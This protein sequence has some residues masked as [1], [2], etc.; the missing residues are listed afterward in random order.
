MIIWI[1]FSWS[2]NCLANLLLSFFKCFLSII[3]SICHHCSWGS[4]LLIYNII[5]PISQNLILTLVSIRFSNLQGRMILMNRLILPLSTIPIAFT[6]DIFNYVFFIIILWSLCL[7]STIQLSLTLTFCHSLI[8][9]LI[10]SGI[11]L[12]KLFFKSLKLVNTTSRFA[13]TPCVLLKV[14]N[15]ANLL[16]FY[17]LWL[18]LLC[19]VP[20]VFESLGLQKLMKTLLGLNFK[21]LYMRLVIL[22]MKGRF[23]NLRILMDGLNLR[24]QN[25]FLTFQHL[26]FRKNK[27]R[28]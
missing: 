20:L 16:I 18:Q 3:T 28:I 22:M 9:P 26:L 17:N 11:N 6:I 2:S 25:L 10:G 21:H 12:I 4:L 15:V 23:N 14:T 19:D 24:F 5:G 7:S 13:L 1:S 8:H 27:M